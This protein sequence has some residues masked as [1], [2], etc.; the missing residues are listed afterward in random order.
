MF[1]Q[2]LRV[3]LSILAV[4][5]T[6]AMSCIPA[7]ASTSNQVIYLPANQVWTLAGTDSR[8]KAYSYVKARNNSVYPASGIDNFQTI[9]CKATTNDGSVMTTKNY[10]QLSETSSDYTSMYV[11]DGYLNYNT[12]YFYFRGNT[13]DSAYAVVSYNAM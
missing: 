9:Q 11:M 1:K 8:S 5:A 2:K 10:Y 13:A 7:L 6:L 12:T 3:T 4:I